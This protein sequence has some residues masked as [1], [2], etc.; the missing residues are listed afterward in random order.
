MKR[1]SNEYV[2]SLGTDTTPPNDPVKMPDL[3]HALVVIL[4]GWVALLVLVATSH[5]RHTVAPWSA[6][7]GVNPTGSTS[8]AGIASLVDHAARRDARRGAMRDGPPATSA[9]HPSRTGGKRPDK[10][11][12]PAVA[13]LPATRRVAARTRAT[14]PAATA[15]G[16]RSARRSAAVAAP[17]R[18]PS[19][20]TP[21][22]RPPPTAAAAGVGAGLDGGGV[23]AP[24]VG[25]KRAAGGVRAPPQTPTRAAGRAQRGT[26][27]CAERQP[28]PSS[29]LFLLPLPSPHPSPTG[30]TRTAGPPRRTP[31]PRRWRGGE[32]GTAQAGRHPAAGAPPPGRARRLRRET[33]AAATAPARPRPSLATVSSHARVSRSQRPAAG[34]PTHRHHTRDVSLPPPT[35][36]PALPATS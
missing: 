28:H 10:P 21:R 22:T 27:P 34:G 14:P 19:P 13:G 9:A 8:L 20:P 29:P 4:P 35:P 2:G 11:A 25:P 7:V 12:Q 36:S 15:R 32:G 18:W 16:R 24:G 23:R 17:P 6:A 5:D 31:P 26:L 1:L 3:A 30:C 33:K